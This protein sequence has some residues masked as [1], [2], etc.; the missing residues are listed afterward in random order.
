M[1]PIPA[2]AGRAGPGAT[3]TM[4]R[5]T[6]DLAWEP[7]C[8]VPEGAGV[9]RGHIAGLDAA[10]DRARALCTGASSAP[11]GGSGRRF[12]GRRPWPLAHAWAWE[13]PAAPLAVLRRHQSAAASSWPHGAR[14]WLHASRMLPLPRRTLGAR[15][16]RPTLRASWLRADLAV[17]W[18]S[19]SRQGPAPSSRH[20]QPSNASRG[21]IPPL[22]RHRARLVPY[23]GLDA[24]S[25]SA[26]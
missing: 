3:A 20:H 12:R 19:R 1:R 6:V 23:A 15:S 13:A 26:V 17:R 25:C 11:L 2:K 16:A 24:G 22:S 18:S 4:A 7:S 5:G 8:D 9:P 21:C 14:R 10:R